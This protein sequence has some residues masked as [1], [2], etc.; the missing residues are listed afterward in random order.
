MK[1]VLL[2]GGSGQIGKEIFNKIKN[3]YE[4]YCNNKKDF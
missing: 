2:L 4:V 3:D 1:K